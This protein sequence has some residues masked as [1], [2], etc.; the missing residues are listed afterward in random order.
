MKNVVRYD[1]RIDRPC[2]K[3]DIRIIGFDEDTT[4]ED[5]ENAILHQ[6]NCNRD[7]IK[8]GVIRRNRVGIGDVWVKC[9]W[10]SAM[11]L[12]RN[13]KMKIG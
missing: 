12:S 7:E 8:I 6:T 9:P 10:T 5:I 2:R 4:G 13:A 11:E 3:A 1:A